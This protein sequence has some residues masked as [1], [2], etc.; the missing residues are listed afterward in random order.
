MSSDSAKWRDT[1]LEAVAHI[2][3]GQSPPGEAT[4]NEGKGLP[5]IGGA[6]DYKGSKLVASRHTTSPTKIC[7]V[8]DLVLCVRATIGRIAVADQSYCLGRGVAGIR[9]TGVKTE[10]LRYF[11]LGQSAALDA[12]GVGT[13]FRQ[14]DKALDQ[15]FD[16]IF[17]EG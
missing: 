13:T 5:L 14:I 4:N 1:T 15:N 6:S 11:L 17:D 10:W 3:M 2:S 16:R 7:K 8:G 9:A 12:A